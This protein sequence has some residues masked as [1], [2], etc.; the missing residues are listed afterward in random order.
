MKLGKINK[1]TIIWQ[2]S[3]QWSAVFLE[4][5]EAYE[6]SSTFT[7]DFC[8]DNFQALVKGY[9]TQIDNSDLGGWIKE[10]NLEL[11]RCQI[12]QGRILDSTKMF[13]KKI[14]NLDRAHTETLAEYYTSHAQLKFWETHQRTT[15]SGMRGYTVLG[16]I[17]VLISHIRKCMRNSVEISERSHTKSRAK[18]ALK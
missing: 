10:T 3:R 15:T 9:R 11:L 8:L 6:F 4:R 16:S 1:A 7:P 17:G 12:L 5:M 18:L 14:S 2:Q 13:R